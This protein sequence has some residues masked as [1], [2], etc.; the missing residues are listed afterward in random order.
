VIQTQKHRSL[1]PR[2]NFGSIH[3]V[4]FRALGERVRF[5]E[6]AEDDGTVGSDPR[7]VDL[8]SP[9]HHGRPV[10]PNRFQIY[11]C[12][13]IGGYPR[14]RL[15]KRKY[16]QP[17]RLHLLTPHRLMAERCSAQPVLNFRHRWVDFQSVRRSAFPKRGRRPA[18]SSRAVGRYLRSS[19]GYGGSAYPAQL[20]AKRSQQARHWKSE[21]SGKKRGEPPPDDLMV[22]FPD[23]QQRRA[24]TYVGYKFVG[25]KD[26][27]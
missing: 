6:H 26:I 23:P 27:I 8:R 21:P 16:R 22:T 3:S 10:L 20:D 1:D 17:A 4:M 5:Q 14:S 13:A 9:V 24:P 15:P 18:W 2:R 19:L 7:R 25:Q 12:G 11:A